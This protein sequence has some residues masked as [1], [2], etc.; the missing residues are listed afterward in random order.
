MEKT[1]AAR[2]AAACIS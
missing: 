2:H 1:M